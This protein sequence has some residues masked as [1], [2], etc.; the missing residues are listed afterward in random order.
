MCQPRLFRDL[1]RREGR[2]KDSSFQEVVG[3]KYFSRYLLRRSRAWISIW[4]HTFLRTGAAGFFTIHS[5]LT[6]LYAFFR[7]IML[8]II[9]LIVFVAIPL[10]FKYNIEIQRNIIFP[11]CEYYFNYFK[12]F[13]VFTFKFLSTFFS[14][15]RLICS[16]Y[17]FC[18]FSTQNSSVTVN[19]CKAKEQ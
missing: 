3:I 4:G 13:Q 17:R 9:F 5:L 12:Q 8:L 11:V 2:K 15:I 10:I 7:S 14:L 16:T 19:G 1:S 18:V 6:V